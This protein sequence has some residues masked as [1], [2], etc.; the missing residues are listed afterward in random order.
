MPITFSYTGSDGC[1]AL[2]PAY[3]RRMAHE[4]EAILDRAARANDKAKMEQWFGK[5]NFNPSKGGAATAASIHHKTGLIRDFFR[6]NVIELIDKKTNTGAFA[7]QDE[8][9][10]KIYLG[11]WFRMNIYSHGERMVTLFHEASH[12]TP[13]LKTRDEKYNGEPAYRGRAVQLSVHS[14]DYS[15]ALTNAENWG[16]YLAS[17][18]SGAGLMAG[19]LRNDWNHT[20]SANQIEMKPPVGG[21]DA[22]LVNSPDCTS[23]Q[24]W[25]N[26][27]GRKE[28]GAGE[29]DVACVQV[30]YVERGAT[31]QTSVY[32]FIMRGD[33]MEKKVLDHVA[34]SFV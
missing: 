15:K 2:D 12:K 9:E 23:G 17:Y 18:A 26:R 34:P 25:Q 22:R 8:P 28:D 4:A 33:I 7:N 31:I 21:S 16:Y 19:P 11:N 3:I 5:G 14:A 32:E 24:K 6:H 1:D 13:G 20:Q 27:R 10:C 29:E 30:P